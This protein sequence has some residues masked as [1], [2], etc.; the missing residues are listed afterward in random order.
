VLH[1]REDSDTITYSGSDAIYNKVGRTPLQQG[2]EETGIA[3]FTFDVSQSELNRP[4]TKW[5]FRVKHIFGR[6]FEAAR[7]LRSPGKIHSFHPGLSY[8]NVPSPSP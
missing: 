4:G 3:S 7:E 1:G 2:A 5:E 6:I 8:L